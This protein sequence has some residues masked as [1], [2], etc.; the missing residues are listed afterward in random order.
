MR[1][2]WLTTGNLDLD[3]VYKDVEVDKN[4]LNPTQKLFVQ[5]VI[6]AKH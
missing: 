6:C 3:N 5:Y 2:E 4:S 1:Q